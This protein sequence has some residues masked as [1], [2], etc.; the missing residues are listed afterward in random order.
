MLLQKNRATNIVT[1]KSLCAE[2]LASACTAAAD[3]F[4]AIA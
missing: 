3:K 2:T 1:L 4:S